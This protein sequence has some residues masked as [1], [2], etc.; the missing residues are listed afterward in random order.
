M[1][2]D[3]DKLARRLQ[4]YLDSARLDGLSGLGH[5]RVKSL[6][7]HEKQ[8]LSN[9][10]YLLRVEA[11]DGSPGD[12]VLRLCSAG[13]R[14]ASAELRVLRLLHSRGLPVPRV[15]LSEERGKPLAKPFMIMEKIEPS[16]VEDMRLVID[17]AARSLVE[18]HS[19]DRA[20]LIGV[21]E[22]GEDY[23]SR[24]LK[25]IKALAAIS[26]FLTL[27]PPTVFRRYRR[28]AAELQKRG[29][30]GR[31]RLI[32]GDCGLDNIIY[33]GGR[34]YMID[35]E[36]VDIGEPTFDVAYA[37]NLLDFEDKRAGRR[38]SRLADTFLDAYTRHGG[39]IRDLEFYRKL[40]AL[41]LLVLTDL[42]T[43]PGLIA[44]LTEGS[45]RLRRN[46]EAR[47]LVKEFRA[48]LASLL[49]ETA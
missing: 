34:A 26:A 28:Y 47:L 20:E 23:P 30:E 31:L 21:L 42:L 7:L 2:A 46:M 25:G 37:Y 10:T 19:L 1:P 22:S 15:Y 41:K 36:S 6:R 45:R 43:S 24:E 8:G 40:A 29:V 48:Y 14:K 49:T 12:Y 35:W 44:I 17:A 16:P 18:I 39:T 38:G 9:R 11:Q 13:G 33:S 32:H 27:K 5:V 3:E 4:A